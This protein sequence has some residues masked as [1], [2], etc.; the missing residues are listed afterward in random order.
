M[1]TAVSI[2]AGLTLRDK[3]NIE[4]M[5]REDI[6]EPYINYTVGRDILIGIVGGLFG[7]FDGIILLCFAKQNPNF[8][9]DSKSNSESEESTETELM[10]SYSSLDKYRY[11]TI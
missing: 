9:L 8:D 1:I 7:I 5:I 10:K 3:W 11:I 4:T 6:R 2:E